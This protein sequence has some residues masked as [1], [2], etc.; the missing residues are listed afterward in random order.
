MSAEKMWRDLLREGS[1]LG[2]HAVAMEV[3]MYRANQC[4]AAARA[5]FE[6]H[7]VEPSP[8]SFAHIQYT[9]SKKEQKLQNRVHLYNAAAG[10][11]SGTNVFFEAGGGTG[12][13]VR[14]FSGNDTE[15]DSSIK[16]KS[17]LVKVPSLRLDDIVANT[18]DG[19]FA[20]KVDTQGFEPN[21]FDGLS[22][23]LKNHKVDFILSEF[24]PRGMKDLYKENDEEECHRATN[25]MAAIVAAGYK[26]YATYNVIAHPMAPAD[27]WQAQDRPLHN[28]YDHCKW[29]L[30]LE[31]RFPTPT[32][33]FG[34]WSDIVAVSPEAHV[35]MPVSTLGLA[36]F[37]KL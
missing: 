16:N 30:D 7:C 12:D 21:V 31:R 29:Y 32:Y 28:L 19:V 27:F 24:W 26:I 15:F 11:V 2:G 36:I 25:M 4:L 22:E 1:N 18:T 8:N 10:D 6:V 9:V 17:N 35:T 14:P 37:G 23:S 3:G 5:G 20:L 33:T 34:Y 13:S